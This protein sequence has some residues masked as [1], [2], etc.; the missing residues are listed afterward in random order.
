MPF[1][2]DPA[3]I[4]AWSAFFI[5][6]RGMFG[7]FRAGDPLRPTPRG[8]AGGNPRVRGGGQT[9]HELLTDGW[10]SNRSG[11]LLPGDYI[12]VST[13][14]YMVVE[15]ASSNSAGVSLLSVEPMLRGEQQDNAVIV[16]TNPQA[17]MRL[18]DNNIG[19]DEDLARIYRFTFSAMEVL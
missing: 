10:P 17:T 18:T 4:G 11:L 8:T 3:L 16:T 15:V 19:W 7:S 12:E 9:G 14:F 13:R 5:S 2:K 1:M 6:L